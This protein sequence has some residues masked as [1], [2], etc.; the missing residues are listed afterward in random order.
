MYGEGVDGRRIAADEPLGPKST[1]VKLTV[2][3]V[4]A[5]KT[6]GGLSQGSLTT[7]SGD[8]GKSKP[9]VGK[10]G[11]D[12]EEALDG[13]AG[14]GG[15]GGGEGQPNPSMVYTFPPDDDED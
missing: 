14:G 8:K 6:G 13:M 10:Q 11:K 3:G 12:Q 1:V 7:G 15:G 2:A 4:K 9:A 5:Q